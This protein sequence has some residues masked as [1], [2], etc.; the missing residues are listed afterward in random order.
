MAIMPRKYTAIIA[1]S[2]TFNYW[3]PGANGER[4]AASVP[5]L[6]LHVQHELARSR[7]VRTSKTVGVAARDHGVAS[8]IAFG[9]RKS[10]GQVG[11]LRR[12]GHLRRDF[13]AYAGSDIGVSVQLQG[14][15]E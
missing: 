12:E 13:I 5:H 9:N 10:I 2:M 7:Q 11:S 8:G 6:E 15:G 4:S 1:K 3:S 14:I